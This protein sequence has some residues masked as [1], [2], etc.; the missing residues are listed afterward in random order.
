MHRKLAPIFSI[1]SFREILR[2]VFNIK[3]IS[4]QKYW[5]YQNCFSRVA[6][7]LQC[8]EVQGQQL[9]EIWICSMIALLTS[10]ETLLRN[11]MSHILSIRKTLSFICTGTDLPESPSFHQWGVQHLW[12]LHNICPVD[13]CLCAGW[14]YE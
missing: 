6:C 10:S 4:Q 9:E 11:L 2:F 14:L 13:L 8:Q 7:F 12:F 1:P 3:N 5:M